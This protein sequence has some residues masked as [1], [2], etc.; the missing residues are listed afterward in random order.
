MPN[1]SVIVNQLASQNKSNS[2]FLLNNMTNDIQYFGV[3][4]YSLC[5]INYYCNL[6]VCTVVLLTS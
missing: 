3:I 6:S 5:F 1:H 2:Y 4:K